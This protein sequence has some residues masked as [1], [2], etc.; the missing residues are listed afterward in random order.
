[1]AALWSLL[2]MGHARS[3]VTLGLLLVAELVVYGFLLVQLDD[4][5]QATAEEVPTDIEVV[6]HKWCCKTRALTS[7][8]PQGAGILT[9]QLTGGIS[10]T[11]AV[12]QFLLVF[13][14]GYG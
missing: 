8:L 4:I 14:P 10:W 7:P 5:S 9:R 6:V 13:V 11:T 3:Y 1:M 12:C 2:L